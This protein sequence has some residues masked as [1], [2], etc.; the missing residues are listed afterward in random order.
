MTSLS[1]HPHVVALLALLCLALVSVHG[2][3]YR[4]GERLLFADEFD[5]LDNEVWEHEL[6]LGGGGNWEFQVSQHARLHSTRIDIARSV[7]T[8]CVSVLRSCC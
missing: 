8:R 4:S 7:L 3:S 5:T 1:R 6:T 2:A